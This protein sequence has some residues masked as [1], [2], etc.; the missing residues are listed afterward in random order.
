M[1][2]IFFSND[3]SANFYK[4]LPNSKPLRSETK[5]TENGIK[6]GKANISRDLQASFT[7]IGKFKLSTF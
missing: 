7:P 1:A 5:A 6:R 4:N 2:K 3:V